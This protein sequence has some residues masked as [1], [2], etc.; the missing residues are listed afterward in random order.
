MYGVNIYGT[1][2]KGN[3]GC[4]MTRYIKIGDTEAP[5]ATWFQPDETTNSKFIA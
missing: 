3:T 1:D 5:T 4:I 2:N